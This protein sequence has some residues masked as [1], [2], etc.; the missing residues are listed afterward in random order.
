MMASRRH[1]LK[2][3]DNSVILV[4]DLN[5]FFLHKNS[6]RHT[7]PVEVTSQ[8]WKNCFRA[9]NAF[10]RIWHE[11]KKHNSVFLFVC[12]ENIFDIFI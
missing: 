11:P 10:P 7:G 3:S 5:K 1:C 2:F 6:I 12:L 8:S 4:P 9:K